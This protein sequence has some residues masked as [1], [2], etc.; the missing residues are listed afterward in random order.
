LFYCCN[1]YSSVT[2]PDDSSRAAQQ[3]SA[4]HPFPTITYTP[5][6]MLRT[7]LLN[8]AGAWSRDPMDT[9]LLQSV[10]QNTISSAPP[11][12]N[13]AGDALLLP[14]VGGPPAAPADT[15]GDG[16]PDAWETAKGLNPNVANHN[17]TTLSAQGFTNLEVYLS[18]LSA[19][20][21]S[22]GTLI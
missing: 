11:N 15:D 7:V 10:A 16:M 21:I 3:L 2:D 22:G 14:Y 18:E 19:S 4:R 12:V 8:T 20:R 1:D 17:A 5:T 13:P 6:D 9:R